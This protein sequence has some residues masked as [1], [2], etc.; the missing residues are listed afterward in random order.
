MASTLTRVWP[1]SQPTSSTI[2]VSPFVFLATASS[3]LALLGV[4]VVLL[5]VD[6]ARQSVVGDSAPAG[7]VVWLRLPTMAFL[8][9]RDWV[10]RSRPNIVVLATFGGYIVAVLPIQ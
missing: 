10:Y 3:C 2:K 8:L 1:S 6:L 7:S 5:A 4:G 9:V